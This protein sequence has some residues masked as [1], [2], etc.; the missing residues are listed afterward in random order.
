MPASGRR[1]QTR[2][3]MMRYSIGDRF[4]ML[5]L[6]SP[7]FS[8]DYAINADGNVIL[9]FAGQIPANGLTN[10]ELERHIRRALIRKGILSEQS[11]RVTVRPIQYAPV[12]VTV[13]GAVFS[14]GRHTI[15]FVRDKEK[16]DQIRS[17]SG[18]GPLDR[19]IPSS[20]RVAGGVR[21]DADLA[22]IKV[23]RDGKTFKL[24]WRGAI[25]GEPVDDM[26]LISGDHVQVGETNCFQSALVRP[27]QIT[28]GGIR[29]FTSNLTT[30]SLGS[31]N[32]QQATGGVAYGTRLLQGLVNANCVGGSYATNARRYAVLISRNPKTGKTEVI[33]RAVEDLVRSADRDAINPFLMPEDAIACYDSGVTEFRD[34]MSVLW[35][36]VPPIKAGT[37]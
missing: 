20:L 31:I 27:T 1:Y 5:V 29:V 32:P 34:V 22:N 13:A 9:P 23:I 30:P 3:P 37:F 11:S 24:N 35:G 26:P 17:Q 25:T 10:D 2:V 14:P 16:I 18:D 36:I 4:N 19:F 33:Q 8:G 15:N 12:N 7:E 28:P 21:P 6:N